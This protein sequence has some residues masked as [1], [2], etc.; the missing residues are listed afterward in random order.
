M[1][2]VNPKKTCV[3]PAAL[4]FRMP[5]ACIKT[6]ILLMLI[7]FTMLML[8]S[9]CAM[10]STTTGDTNSLKG[11]QAMTYKGAID[12]KSKVEGGLRYIALQDTALS[13]GAQAGLAAAAQRFN[14]MLDKHHANL[15]QA[16]NFNG[17]LLNDNV[18]PPVLTETKQTVNQSDD[19]TLRV[20]GTRYKIEQ[21]ARFVTAPPT[22]RDYLR[23]NFEPPEP[24]DTTLLPRTK[25][26]QTLWQEKV[27]Q[28]WNEGIKQANTIYAN[29]L[30]LLQRDLKG[31]IIYHKLLNQHMVSKP[32]V[33]KTEL[34]VTGGGKDMSIDDKVLRITSLPR[35]E[36]RTDRWDPAVAR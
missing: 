9:S 14:K 17:L 6:A 36:A 24:P 4:K 11:L 3:H 29:N 15:D 27:A 13:V 21:E 31:M 30:S 25:T 16:F 10:I 8:L 20:S 34:G 1:P 26:E 32:F 18:L 5:I 28:G 19:N 22:W 2:I 7:S 35:L 23:L 12:E 33:A